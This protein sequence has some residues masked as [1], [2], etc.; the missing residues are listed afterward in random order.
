ME[1]HRRARPNPI[2]LFFSLIVHI[3]IIIIIIVFITRLCSP[4]SVL[5]S[6]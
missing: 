2:H 3:I 6:C 4:L 1:S 5:E